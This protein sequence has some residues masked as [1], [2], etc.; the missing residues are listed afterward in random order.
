MERL[1]ASRSETLVSPLM[2]TERIITISFYCKAIHAVGSQYLLTHWTEKCVLFISVVTRISF[3]VTLMIPIDMNKLE[4]GQWAEQPSRVVCHFNDIQMIERLLS[5]ER[6]FSTIESS[7]F[8]LRF[9]LFCSTWNFSQMS[10]SP[11]QKSRLSLSLSLKA[12]GIASVLTS[13]QWTVTYPAL[14]PACFR[15]V[16]R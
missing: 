12:W 13:L 11:S 9:S 3:S 5:V 7:R 15:A 14:R 6:L 10:L 16:A 2:P 4:M 8:S 1:T